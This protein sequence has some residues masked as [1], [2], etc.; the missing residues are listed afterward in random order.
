[1][2]SKTVVTSIFAT[3]IAVVFA[4]GMSFAKSSSVTLMYQG[5]IGNHLILKPGN[6]KIMVNDNTK[7]P[8][9]A[10][11]QGRKLVGQTPVKLVTQPNKADQTAVYYSAPHNNVR[12]VSAIDL[13]GWNQ[14]LVFPASNG[15]AKSD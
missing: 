7:T 1:M 11:Y 14:K 4:A 2:M 9:A 3:A 12:E 10:F 13:N 15:S 5:K 6:Y 8:E